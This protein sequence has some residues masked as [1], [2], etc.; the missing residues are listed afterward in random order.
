MAK[1][2]NKVN[3]SKS[4][5]KNVKNKNSYFKEMKTELKKVIWPTPKQLINNTV[6]VIVSVLITAIIVFVLDV[7]FDLLNKY[8]FGTL[9]KKVQSVYNN[10]QSS[11]KTSE[12]EESQE[13]ANQ[14]DES[15]TS[16]ENSNQST[17]NSVEVNVTDE[18][19]NEE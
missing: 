19:N 11:E 7:A 2:E 13:D 18:S 12:N 16:G 6:A 3:D 15:S 1:K 8:G 17:E 10:S 5:N 14:L 9:Q 4:N